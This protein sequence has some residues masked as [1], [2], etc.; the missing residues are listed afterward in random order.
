MGCHAE[1]VASIGELE[2]AWRRAKAA[3]RTT[4]IALRTHQNSWTEG[5]AWWEVGVPEVSDRQSVRDA[6]AELE[7][8]K[9]DQRA[10]W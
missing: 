3:D 6:R 4:V 9:T 1:T 10:G 5:G 2:A 8:G 7:A